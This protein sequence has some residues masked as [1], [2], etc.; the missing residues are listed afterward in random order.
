MTGEGIGTAQTRTDR[1]VTVPNALSVIRLIGVPVFLYLLV[2]LEADWWAFALL[3]VSGVTDWLDGKLARLLDQQS[4]LGALLDP[5]VDRLYMLATLAGFVIRGIVPW[6]LAALLIARDAVLAVT[7]TVYKRR[8]LDPPDVIYLGKAAT[9]AL[10]SA[11][12]WVL[13]AQA[14]WPGAAAAGAF[15]YAFLVWGSVVY[16][17]TGLLYIWKAWAVARAIPVVES[18]PS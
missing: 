11:F 14:D 6:W 16:V 10:M 13:A 17:W 15:G 18:R 2:V 12:P 7:L 4:R 8:D 1:I 3:V 5:L 9:F